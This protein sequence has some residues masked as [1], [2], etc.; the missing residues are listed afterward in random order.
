MRFI[1][2]AVAEVV[3]LFVGDWTQTVVSVAIIGLGW[4][5]LPR[6]HLVGLAFVLC[7]ALAAQLIV[8]TAAEA[9]RTRK[10]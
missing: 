6:L 2:A 9:Q 5:A 7:V 3:G 8:A 10:T 1:R 4:F